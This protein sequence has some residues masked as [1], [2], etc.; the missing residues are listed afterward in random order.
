MYDRDESR[1]TDPLPQTGPTGMLYEA[2]AEVAGGINSGAELKERYRSGE[3]QSA[4]A[5]MG[6]RPPTRHI[7]TDRLHKLTALME[8]THQEAEAARRA[9][10]ILQE[11]PEFGDLIDALVALRILAGGAW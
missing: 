2:G 9:N 4:Y 1:A 7:V 10:R 8:S 3:N 11:H 5:Q 6:R